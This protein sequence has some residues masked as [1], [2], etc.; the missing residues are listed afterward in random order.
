MCLY[1]R[2]NVLSFIKIL[3][4]LLLVFLVPFFFVAC[5]VFGAPAVYGDTF[6]GVLKDKYER[7]YSL[8][9]PKI[10]II[11]GSSVPFGIDSKMVEEEMGMPVVN[12]GLY[13]DLGTKLMLELSRDHIK[14]GD[15][16]ILAPELDS[17]TLSS[18]F[19]WNNRNQ[20]R[21]S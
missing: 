13:A 1:E 6:V 17:Q 11:G 20:Q 12:F 14:T 5:V 3:L 2:G 10:V 19:S 18:Y 9:D 21:R 7:L 4:L 15:I 16:V 8:E